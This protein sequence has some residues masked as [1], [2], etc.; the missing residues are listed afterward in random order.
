MKPVIVLAFFLVH[1]ASVLTCADSGKEE[2]DMSWQLNQL[3]NHEVHLNTHFC[4]F[5]KF[6][7]C[8]FREAEL[9][10]D[11]MDV[12]IIAEP[13][14]TVWVCADN[15]TS[16][17][18]A[19]R[20]SAVSFTSN[21]TPVHQVISSTTHTKLTLV[22]PSVCPEFVRQSLP[23]EA[24]K[25]FWSER[26]FLVSLVKK[27]SE[28]P[29]K[30]K[31][32]SSAFSFS[33]FNPDP[34]TVGQQLVQGGGIT[35][36]HYRDDFFR[37]RR[38]E[39]YFVSGQGSTLT[40][41]PLV[42]SDRD[43]QRILPMSQ[44][45]HWLSGSR[46][47]GAGITLAVRFNRNFPVYLQISQAEFHALSRILHDTRRVLQYLA[48]RLSG[49]Q[50]FIEQL[51]TLYS[52]APALNR[53]TQRAIRRQIITL[54][55][56]PDTEFS[57]DFEVS[58]LVR[59]M[60]E[61]VSSKTGTPSQWIRQLPR[62]LP[63]SSGQRPVRA[64]SHS[65][66]SAS[67]SR[68]LGS[69]KSS[70][71][72]K[73]QADQD[74]SD[75]RDPQAIATMPATTA[76]QKRPLTITFIGRFNSGKSSLAN[77]LLGIKH[78]D[79]NHTR[80]QTHETDFRTLPGIRIRA[81][82]GYGS[83]KVPSR[84]FPNQ[85][86]E[87][88]KIDPYEIVV[89]VMPDQMDRKDKQVLR[90][91]I[92]G[93]HKLKRI[94]FVRGHFDAARDS[95][96]KGLQ[97][98]QSSEQARDKIEKLKDKQR[99]EHEKNLE[100]MLADQFSHLIL[101]HLSDERVPEEWKKL[102]VLTAKDIS[103]FT[104]ED[105]HA[106]VEAI[107]RT[108][109]NDEERQEFDNFELFRPKN[110]QDVKAKINELAREVIDERQQ[111]VFSELINRLDKVYGFNLSEIEI[112]EKLEEFNKLFGGEQSDC[113]FD[114]DVLTD[115]GLQTTRL[116]QFTSFYLTKIFGEK[117]YE[118]VSKYLDK[119]FLAS[120]DQEC[121][122]HLHQW[123]KA[124]QYGWIRL[125]LQL[126]SGFTRQLGTQREDV[127]FTVKKLLEKRDINGRTPLHL[128]VYSGSLDTVKA[129]LEHDAVNSIIDA[130][131]KV[132]YT[133]LHWAA[134]Y[135]KNDIACLLLRNGA[136]VTGKSV[137][138]PHPLHLAS[139]AGQVD[140]IK[141]LIDKGG[142]PTVW[143]GF[144]PL[145]Y[146]V[147]GG[148]TD[149]LS[150]LLASKK[151]NP[152]ETG[153]GG[154]TALHWAN[155]FNRSDV[156]KLLLAFGGD[157]Q[158]KNSFDKT[159]EDL[160]ADS[161]YKLL[162]GNTKWRTFMQQ[163]QLMEG[164][165]VHEFYVIEAPLPPMGCESSYNALFEAIREGDKEK[166]IAEIKEDSKQLANR[167]GHNNWS[168]LHLAAA[169][170]HKHIIE[171][172]LRGC[173]VR[174]IN[175]GDGNQYTPLHRAAVMGQ[176]SAVKTLLRNEANI[177]WRTVEGAT[178]FHLA[179]QSGVSEL[180]A[181]FTD[182]SASCNQKDYGGNTAMHKAA[183][184][185]HTG[186]TKSLLEL[187]L[188][189]EAVN[190]NGWKPLHFAAFYGH[191]KVVEQLKD[192]PVNPNSLT[193]EGRA[194]IHMAVAKNHINVLLVLIDWADREI[195]FSTS[196]AEDKS[197]HFNGENKINALHA[198]AARGYAEAVKILVLQG[199]SANIQATDSNGCTAM[200]FAASYGHLEV[201]DFL[202]KQSKSLIHKK[203]SFIGLMQTPLA[204]AMESKQIEA[205]RLL[206]KLGADSSVSSL[207]GFFS[208]PNWLYTLNDDNIVLLEDE[209]N[210]GR[211]PNER[212]HGVCPLH[213]AAGENHSEVVKL[214]AKKGADLY[215]KT[216]WSNGGFTPLQIAV[217]CENPKVTQA[218]FEAG[219]TV[220]LSD[221]HD[222]PLITLSVIP[223]K[224]W[225][226]CNLTTAAAI[227]IAEYF[228]DEKIPT[229][230]NRKEIIE[231]LLAHGASLEQRQHNNW[232]PLHLVTIRGD[233][234]F[235]R[236]L[237]KLGSNTETKDNLGRTALHWAAQI[238]NEPLI[239]LLLEYK[240]SL[241][242]YNNKGN[243]PLHHTIDVNGKITTLN[244]LLAHGANSNAQ[245]HKG[246]TPL[247]LATIKKQ[248]N[249]VKA[250]L[251][252]GASLTVKDKDGNNGLHYIFQYLPV[253]EAESIVHQFSQLINHDL[254]STTNRDSIH[255]VEMIKKN[256]HFKWFIEGLTFPIARGAALRDARQRQNYGRLRLLEAFSES[257]P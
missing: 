189:P 224:G 139:W 210:H 147:L 44:W 223:N 134:Y 121:P 211:S 146:A 178:A 91:L 102:L 47:E 71:I 34:P 4:S 188:D 225:L 220:A 137:D 38:G 120:V 253:D 118:F 206:K 7:S 104:D 157:E 164:P 244:W 144:T 256:D 252:K 13:E 55:D 63:E 10:P 26:P 30:G 171:A 41:L 62:N 43:W 114:R 177:S 113:D 228:V 56:W 183:I 235:T 101:P 161:W 2:V 64:G 76:S 75:Q 176:T 74:A 31:R 16:S 195:K 85:Q 203:A 219:C 28:Q 240:A 216:H 79:I 95:V 9:L 170:G 69:D 151:I 150:A 48:P 39:G 93:G 105:D 152:N 77:C 232:T 98:S 190:N 248:V 179:A 204:V 191:H 160:L 175:I 53:Q 68:D 128:A 119:R 70:G 131:D 185:G 18:T 109:L 127:R 213:F 15:L 46:D 143:V 108:D 135:G 35:F 202:A 57:L 116:K 226:P 237:L 165:I 66:E 132:G 234:D 173:Y 100:S 80:T 227:K 96:L 33:P 106:L 42:R 130:K 229:V 163:C 207:P 72:K 122:S 21:L 199:Q 214:L 110:N 172:L 50:A 242:S 182:F 174:E 257:R 84:K 99:K 40:L 32:G 17:E 221:A 205:A 112:G 212:V 25:V 162:S 159:P 6:S 145:D 167:H 141:Q 222:T 22:K 37:R 126:A 29:A 88:L 250:L 230:E 89:M 201:I 81:L 82:E 65:D 184:S 23:Y 45:W 196:N 94:I 142:I 249:K 209:L 245:N 247:M 140:V 169:C 73:Q 59:A 181:V 3:H 208:L 60:D 218:L 246:E 217:M 107:R 123:A 8:L 14:Q 136:C 251:D 78:F 254:L 193:S 129:L 5:H 36:D 124:G 103:T 198:A 192:I 158:I 92:M 24:G 255:P 187:G 51:L 238:D 215:A 239:E 54:L 166:M 154:N 155:Y 197:Y 1:V 97:M 49:R 231:L 125:L 138:K 111:Q 148:K 117:C 90:S 153:S 12:I 19:T 186:I 180:M 194:A 52:S 115:E 133:P 168:V 241:E 11:N 86:N 156:I 83:A 236:L 87:N 27:Y 58:Q 61:P 243:T 200:H 67:S 20:V 233:L 149:S